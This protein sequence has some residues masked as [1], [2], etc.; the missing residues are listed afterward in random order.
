MITVT[1]VVE[2][3][4]RAPTLPQRNTIYQFIAWFSALALG[5]VAAV[6]LGLLMAVAVG[7]I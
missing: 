7:A 6:N 1:C 3:F 4:V 2:A 5:V